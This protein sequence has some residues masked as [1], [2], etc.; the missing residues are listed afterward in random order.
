SNCGARKNPAKPRLPICLTEVTRALAPS[1]SWIIRTA[2][3][4]ELTTRRYAAP[5]NGVIGSGSAISGG[6]SG[7]GARDEMRTGLGGDA[8]AL[9]LHGILE[10]QLFVLPVKQEEREHFLLEALDR[11]LVRFFF[12]GWC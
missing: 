11:R 2:S 5:G 4:A 9:G 6:G 3:S 1:F 7:V 12:L 8:E 10:E